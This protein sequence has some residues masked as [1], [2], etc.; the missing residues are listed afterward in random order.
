MG[1]DDHFK[2]AAHHVT[3]QFVIVVNSDPQRSD[4]ALSYFNAQNFEALVRRLMDGNFLVEE[5]N[6]LEGVLD[7]AVDGHRC[8]IALPPACS[9]ISV[10]DQE[11]LYTMRGM[12]KH[13]DA[14]SQLKGSG[15][16]VV[17]G[18]GSTGW[19]TSAGKYLFPFGRRWLRTEGRA[20]IVHREPYGSDTDMQKVWGVLKKGEEIRIESSSNH[21]PEVSVDS[22]W[23][24]SFPRGSELRIWIC[25]QPLKV[26]SNQSG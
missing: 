23:R 3:D 7:T 1:G 9:E 2:A 8:R 19:F 20:E 25:E 10:A 11:T 14:E 4:G 5:W 22:V 13:G 6:R 12:L 15:V 18:A 17:P 16:L 26:I 24:H 21:S